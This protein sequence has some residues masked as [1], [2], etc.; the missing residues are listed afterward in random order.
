LPGAFNGDV[1]GGSAVFFQDAG[2]AGCDAGSA[3]VGDPPV[4]PVVGLSPATRVEVESA[5]IKILWS[6]INY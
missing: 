3:V 1:V 6:L 4:A 2:F 5:E